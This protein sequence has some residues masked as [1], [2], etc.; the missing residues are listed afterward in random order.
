MHRITLS[1]AVVLSFI[2]ALFSFTQTSA[3]DFGSI[4]SE[5]NY[6]GAAPQG[7]RLGVADRQS[8]GSLRPAPAKI[9]RPNSR[10]AALLAPVPRSPS[11]AA[12]NQRG[13]KPLSDKLASSPAK[14]RFQSVG[15]NPVGHLLGHQRHGLPSYGCSD[16]DRSGGVYL[17]G[18]GCD[19]CGCDSCVAPRKRLKLP[20]LGCCGGGCCG[21]IIDAGCGCRSA[22][23]RTGCGLGKCK[24]EDTSVCMPRTDVNLPSSTLRQYFRSG[25]C[26]TN[27]WDGYTQKCGPNHEHAH[28]T[29]DC[30]LKKKRGCCLGGCCGE[31]LPPRQCFDGCDSACDVGCDTCGSGCGGGCGH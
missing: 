29:C 12:G 5:L 28:G 27:I 1:V 8:V 31:I 20:K 4:L 9:N 7:S 21:E 10:A 6:R 11:H 25:R 23:G 22:C 26:N 19:D 3:S 14:P 17:Q 15:A 24:Q 2:A 18:G 13:S 16:C 30:H